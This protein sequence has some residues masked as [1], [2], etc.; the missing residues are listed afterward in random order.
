MDV[1]PHMDIT[2]NLTAAIRKQG[3]YMGLYHSLR[4][5]YHPLYL[6]VD[7]YSYKLWTYAHLI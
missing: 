5:W 3:L 2:G 4:E 1:G 6:Q 7:T